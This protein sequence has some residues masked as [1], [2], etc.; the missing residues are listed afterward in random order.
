MYA[1]YYV[2]FA[3]YAEPVFSTDREAINYGVSK[4]FEFNVIKIDGDQRTTVHTWNPV[5]GIRH[6]ECLQVPE[7]T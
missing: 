3:Y 1:I 5:H 6:L 7:K 4:G 2:N